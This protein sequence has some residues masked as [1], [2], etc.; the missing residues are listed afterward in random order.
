MPDL[1][2]ARSGNASTD[3]LTPLLLTFFAF[4]GPDANQL[5][6]Q[7]RLI[8]SLSVKGAAVAVVTSGSGDRRP[9]GSASWH[10]GCR[11][12]WIGWNIVPERFLHHVRNGI[13]NCLLLQQ[14]QGRNCF[15]G[16]SL[17]AVSGV[18]LLTDAAHCLLGNWGS[19][20]SMGSIQRIVKNCHSC[21]MTRAS[22]SI[23]L[24]YTPVS[25]WVRSRQRGTVI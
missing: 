12:H 4:E 22:A 16:S 1:Q 15:F 14:T 17:T 24:L 8:L 23:V 20:G 3:P 2:T 5:H 18:S 13:D 25:R 19:R 10:S 21:P 7:S 11:I 9:L 6:I